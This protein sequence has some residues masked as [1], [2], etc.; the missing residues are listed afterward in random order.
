M[1]EEAQEAIFTAQDELLAEAQNSGLLAENIKEEAIA[2]N[3]KWFQRIEDLGYS[4]GGDFPEMN[5]WYIP[6]E[7]DFSEY[8]DEVY[9]EVVL[10]H[11]PG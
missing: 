7:V 1:E 2:T 4:D 5:E 3:E 8:A 6:G 11:R 10:P 9:E